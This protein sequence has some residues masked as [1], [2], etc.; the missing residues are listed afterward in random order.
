MKIKWVAPHAYR[1][2]IWASLMHCVTSINEV[3]PEKREEFR[4]LKIP[5]I[6]QIAFTRIGELWLKVIG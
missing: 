5:G 1:G 6:E 4:R 2:E 3:P